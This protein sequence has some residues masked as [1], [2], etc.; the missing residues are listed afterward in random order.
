MASLKV[1]LTYDLRTDYLAEG[2]S[3]EETAEFDKIETV[4]AIESALHASGYTTDRIGNIKSLS[5][6]LISGE[7]WD[8]VFNIAEGM[9][10]VAREGQV[11]AL[12]DA[13]NIP[14][15]FSDT[16]IMALTLHKGLTKRV[17]RDLGVATADFA[18]VEKIDDIEKINLSY[19]MFAKPAAEGNGKGIAPNSIIKN[20]SELESV[21]SSL[22]SKFDGPVIVEE[23]LPGR[24]FTVGIVG[25]GENSRAIGTLEVA[26]TEKGD[27]NVYSYENKQNCHEFCEYILIK[28][29]IAEKCEKTA[30]D[31]WKGLGCRDAGRIDLRYDSDGI[32]NFLEVNPVAGLNPIDSDLPI[33][34]TKIGLPYNDL[35]KQI[36]DS[37]ILRIK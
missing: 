2:F 9:Y 14:Y 29:E 4:E 31:A 23:F 7:K 30:L 33:I 15:T 10:G 11:P 34:C 17:I 25:T 28:G 22:V 12:L 36:M 3:D 1:G 19:P 8:I 18:I 24:E 20:K 13:Y 35:I 27:Q 32:P 6:R 5:K 26:S 37:A 21:C 16:L